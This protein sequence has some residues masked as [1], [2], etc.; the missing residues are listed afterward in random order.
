[1]DFLNF[2]HPTGEKNMDGLNALLRKMQAEREGGGD[3]VSKQDKVGMLRLHNMQKL[4]SKTTS[5]RFECQAQL[6]SAASE[7]GS[8][9][10]PK[11]WDNKDDHIAYL[12]ASIKA[13]NTVLGAKTAA[14]VA[15]AF[16][17]VEP[18]R[19]NIDT[20]L[21]DAHFWFAEAHRGRGVADTRPF[22]CQS[23]GTRDRGER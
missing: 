6:L 11:Q 16:D 21:S 12:E 8:D 15:V 2:L 9:Y 22:R 1:M 7:L 4:L 3:N 18:F 14:Q 10:W 5:T 17:A 13:A 19:A 20:K 23:M